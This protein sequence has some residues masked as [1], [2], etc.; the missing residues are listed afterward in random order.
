MSHA[1]DPAT[2]GSQFFILLA[3]DASLNGGY[4]AFGEVTEGEGM[5]VVEAISEEPGEPFGIEGGVKP[6]EVQHVI[7]CWVE[8]RPTT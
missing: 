1:S 5:E 6:A 3:D 8:Q 2:A 4:T 7:A